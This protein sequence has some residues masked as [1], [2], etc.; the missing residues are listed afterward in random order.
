[1]V[2]QVRRPS[3]TRRRNGK[4]PVPTPTK[5]KKRGRAA[6]GQGIGPV[7]GAFLGINQEGP[8]SKAA[9]KAKELKEATAAAASPGRAPEPKKK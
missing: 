3:E 7:M 5:K 9:S 6:K 2:Y 1:M 4:G 8:R